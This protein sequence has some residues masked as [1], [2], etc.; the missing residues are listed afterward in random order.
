MAPVAKRNFSRRHDHGMSKNKDTSNAKDDKVEK[1]DDTL[2]KSDN[3]GSDKASLSSTT[4]PP[5]V[6]SSLKRTTKQAPIEEKPIEKV[7]KRQKV[8]ITKPRAMTTPVKETKVKEKKVKKTVVKENGGEDL[9]AKRLAMWNDLLIK[10]PRSKDPK[11]LSSWL[12]EVLAVSDINFPLEQVSGNLDQPYGKLLFNALPKLSKLTAEPADDERKNS[13]GLDTA[14]KDDNNKSTSHSKGA[15]N[16]VGNNTSS[17]DSAKNSEETKIA[18]T[19]EAEQSSE[20]QNCAKKDAS[21]T[22]APEAN[23]PETPAVKNKSD[24][25]NKSTELSG[26]NSNEEKEGD[27]FSGSFADW[28]DRKKSKLIKKGSGSLRK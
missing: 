7:K 15:D 23:G 4:K 9:S 6:A 12:N 22:K 16:V 8:E 25:E 1:D 3:T 13:S 17:T 27:G 28:R 5:A 21:I 11:D 20:I 19:A 10:R 18:V 24:S 2:D 26:N 14:A